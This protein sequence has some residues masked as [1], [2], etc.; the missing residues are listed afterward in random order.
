MTLDFTRGLP[1]TTSFP[2]SFPLFTQQQLGKHWS[3]SSRQQ[4][5]WTEMLYEFQ[6]QCWLMRYWQPGLPWQSQWQ[7]AAW[8]SMAVTVSMIITS[9]VPFHLL[10][11][12]KKKKKKSVQVYFHPQFVNLGPKEVSIRYPHKLSYCQEI[13]GAKLSILLSCV[14]HGKRQR[15]NKTL[16]ILPQG[17]A[18]KRRSQHS[19]LGTATHSAAEQK[20]GWAH[21]GERRKKWH[22]NPLCLEQHMVFLAWHTRSHTA[23]VEGQ[24]EKPIQGT[25]PN[26]AGK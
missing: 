16:L 8:F 24:R 5:Q 20:H 2:V 3:I 25:Y 22:K 26:P 23:L 10:F 6:G 9:Y 18:E 11:T 14:C 21:G 17:R 7:P 4:T 12:E 15:R 19:T 13:A 1:G